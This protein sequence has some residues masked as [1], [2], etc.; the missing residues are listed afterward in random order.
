MKILVVGDGE[1]DLSIF[2][3]QNKD[4]LYLNLREGLEKDSNLLDSYQDDHPDLIPKVRHQINQIAPDKI[5][6]LGRLEGYLWVGT[7]ICR[8]FGQFNSW[9]DQWSNPYGVTELKVA[10]KL[11]KL[12]AIKSL[13]DWSVTE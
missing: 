4:V 2:Q 9:I 10:D 8:F 11:I 13:E 6:A 1:L 5:V 7:V 12:Y 3:K